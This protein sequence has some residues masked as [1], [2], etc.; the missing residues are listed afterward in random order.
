MGNR[1]T[2]KQRVQKAINLEEPDF[3]PLY[4]TV[5]PQVAEAI[6]KY[7]EI[8]S[9][10]HADSPLS[11]NRISYTE[12]LVKLG[13]DIVGIG[14]CAP[15]N[16]PTRMVA[17]DV[18]TNEWNIQYKKI[19]NYVE[20]IE[21]PLA[22]AKSIS[23]IDA[24]EFP[25]P[26]AEGRYELAKRTVEKY[27]N[28]YSICG[29]AECSIFEASWY[30]VG[31]EKFLVDMAMDKDYTFT[32]MDRMM[33]YTIEVSKELMGIGADIIWL[34]DD[35][36]TQKGLLMSRDMW[37]KVLKNRLKRIIEELKGMNPR[38]KI[39][40]H[41]CGSYYPIIPDLIEIGVDILNALQPTATDMEL[42][43]LK[44]DFGNKVCLF[45][46][47]DI[48]KTLPFGSIED[49]RNETERAI[50]A[51][52]CGGGYILAG[53]HNLQPDTS[54]EKVLKLFQFAREFGEYPIS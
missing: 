40:Y 44:N 1:L 32:L 6:A 7:L 13:N 35:V 48:Q 25:D 38:I 8:E 9:Y 27:G 51:A 16:N 11:E 33:D 17:E 37:N 47:L 49:I 2:S 5:T 43:Q 20:M 19:G 23:D 50:Q 14:A 30:L 10:T 31:F 42:E 45:G 39:A 36:G 41:C 21:H 22:Q 54:I 28:Q 12:L 18:F 53:A 52:A 3:V 46:G 24:F 4:I 26:H 29:D 34:G 15:K